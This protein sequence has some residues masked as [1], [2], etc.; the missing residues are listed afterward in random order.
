VLARITGVNMIGELS[1]F[2]GSLAGLTDGFRERAQGVERLLRD[3]TTGFLIV[4]SPEPE[5]ARE[6]IFLHAQLKRETMNFTGLIVN[7]VEEHGL[8]GH[9]PGDVAQLLSPRLGVALAARV[10]DNLAD[11][12]VLVKRDRESVRQ[13]ARALG[14]SDPLLVPHL[15]SDVQDLGGLAVIAEHLFA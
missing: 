12:D 8:E 13:L 9:T 7:H 5:Q 15:D 14:E 10:A 11:Y 3:E 1:A 2:F 6:A 4:T